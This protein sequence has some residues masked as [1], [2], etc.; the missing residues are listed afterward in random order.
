M[1]AYVCVDVYIYVFLPPVFVAE[2]P[3]SDLG[4]FNP[5]ETVPILP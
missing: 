4:R 1:K 5:G 3:A 2:W